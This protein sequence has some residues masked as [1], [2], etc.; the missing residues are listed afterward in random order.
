M[1]KNMILVVV[2]IVVLLASALFS[3][4]Q[5][6]EYSKSLNSIKEEK[7]SIEYIASLKS[8]WDAKG[9]KSKI[10]KALLS[11]PKER[12]KSYT[13]KR[14]KANIEFNSLSE[15]ELNRILSK[16]SILPLQF[17][18]LKVSKVSNKFIL[19]IQCVW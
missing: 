15:R 4:S 14:G 10:E 16:L 17:K 2:S 3:I 7:K 13:Q 9:I 18:E 11:I 5:K 1:S 8:L 12:V 6:K 19:E